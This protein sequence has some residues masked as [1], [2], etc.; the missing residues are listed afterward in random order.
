MKT[1]GLI[2]GMS[3]EST[4]TYYQIINQTVQKEL[5]GFHS[6]KIVLYSVDFHE[7]EA[8]LSSG[9]WDKGAAILS[10][11]AKKLQNAGAECLLICTNT[12]HKVADRVQ[13]SV[14][15]P[16]LHI[17]EAVAAEIK[18]A[19]VTKAAL[20]GTKFTMKEDFYRGILAD[21]GIEEIL[22]EER[23]WDEINRVIFEELCLGV[24][25]EKSKAEYLRIIG[26]LAKAGA[27]AVILGC[28]EIGLII[29]QED[30]PVP[31]FDTTVLHA[32]KAAGF[33]LS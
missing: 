29:T 2:G 3:W 20:I 1:I 18:Y 22:P 28:T 6:A 10:D 17:A 25:S 33:A 26:D 23:D 12:L 9:D 7:I 27:Q 8:C 30:T 15:V 5:G 11:A 24:I 4:V 31:L 14:S 19:G 21:Y 32:L 16:V 13:A